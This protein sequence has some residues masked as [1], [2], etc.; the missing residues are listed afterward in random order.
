[1]P[2]N[3]LGE[4]SGLVHDYDVH[5][6]AS[7]DTGGS[8]PADADGDPV[9]L[10]TD[11][12]GSDN[13]SQSTSSKKPTIVEDTNGWRYLQGDGLDDYLQ[14]AF[15][16]T[17]NQPLTL[18][19]VA[20]IP[21][22]SIVIDGVNTNFKMIYNNSQEDWKWDLGNNGSAGS[23]F[24]QY[25]RRTY[26]LQADGSSSAFYSNN[27]LENGANYGSN[28]MDGITLCGGGNLSQSYHFSN[29]KVWRVAVYNKVLSSSE[30]SD[31]VTLLE[32]DTYTQSASG[33]GSTSTSN[34]TVLGT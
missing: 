16:S 31:V 5:N 4:I 22:G 13:L 2:I 15:G 34:I 19:L 25:A 7:Q 21:S 24:T 11:Q 17:V 12:A 9:G 23:D 33:G 8:T 28:G 18:I 30:R 3:T 6:A 14:I 29:V 32:D 1:M 26:I 27:N 10:L 20:D